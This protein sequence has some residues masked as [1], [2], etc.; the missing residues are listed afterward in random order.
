VNVLVGCEFSGKVREA[1]RAR[2]HNAWS[3]D[4]LPAADGSPFHHQCD[5]LDILDAGWDLAVFHPPC[6]FLCNSGVRW[7]KER[8]E[9]W[10]QMADGVEFFNKLWAAPIERIAVENPVM[11]RYAK[12]LLA[13]T[14]TQSV[15]PW[16][17]GD[18]AFKRTGFWLR[19]LPKLTPTN[20]LVPPKKGT[21]E[22][23][24]WSKVHRASPGT[25][26]WALRSETFPGIAQAMA[27]QWG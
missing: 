21:E 1:F 9:R 10:Q 5:V 20:V 12:A 27:E 11:H 24:R 2:G 18:K 17:F 25:N 14:M 8:P 22:H 15:Q 16:Q 6:T 19:G 4:I 13:S 3:C 23:K 7:L 26:R